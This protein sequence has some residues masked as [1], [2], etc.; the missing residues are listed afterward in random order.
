MTPVYIIAKIKALIPA[1][2]KL[3]LIFFA[4]KYISVISPKKEE[5]INA[6]CLNE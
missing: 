4:A 2:L 6:V 3:I 1:A 5:N